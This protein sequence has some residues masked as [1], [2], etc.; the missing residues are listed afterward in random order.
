[1]RGVRRRQEHGLCQVQGR[2]RCPGHDADGPKLVLA[3]QDGREPDGVD[4]YGGRF[5]RRRT[6][7]AARDPRDRLPEGPDPVHTGRERRMI[8]SY[9]LGDDGTLEQLGEASIP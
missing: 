9:V 3:E 4:D 5:R 7:H 1:M 6:H 8:D 2:A